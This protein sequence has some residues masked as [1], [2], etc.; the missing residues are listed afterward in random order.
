[1]VLLDVVVAVVL[2][3]RFSSGVFWRVLLVRVSCSRLGERAFSGWCSIVG[4]VFKLLL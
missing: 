3:Q 1:M 4:D 2:Q